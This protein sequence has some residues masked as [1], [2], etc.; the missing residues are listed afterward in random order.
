MFS[1]CGHQHAHR[2]SNRRRRGAASGAHRQGRD[3]LLQH[4]DLRALRLDVTARRLA[5]LS[6]LLAEPR[7][8]VHERVPL[9]QQRLQRALHRP[10]LLVRAHDRQ[11]PRRL[12]SCRSRAL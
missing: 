7:A 10:E 12:S 8:V 11:R 9:E 4:L 6:H 5:Q 3:D 2:V 1:R